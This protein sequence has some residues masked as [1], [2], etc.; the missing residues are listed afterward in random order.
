MQSGDT[1]FAVSSGVGRAAVCVIRI[2]GSR[3]QYV[4]DE[5]CDGMR[6]TPRLM[7]LCTLQDPHTGHF[8]DHALV[9]FFEGPKSFTGE[10]S[11]ELHVH[12]S[13]AVKKA[14]LKTLSSLEG[15]RPAERGEFTQR[16]FL[17]RKMDLAQVEGLAD[18]IDSETEQQRL[19]AVRQMDGI[20]GS[21]VSRWREL[22]LKALALIEGS[23]D[24]SDEEDVSDDCYVQLIALLEPLQQE[25]NILLNNRAGE[26]IRESFSIV[27]AGKP[28]TGKS[29]LLNLLSRRDVA[30]VSDIPGTTRDTLEVVCDLDGYP[31]IFTDTAGLRD[32]DDQIE[33][34]GVNRAKMKMASADLVLWLISP[35]TFSEEDL[36]IHDPVSVIVVATKSDLGEV[37]CKTDLAISVKESSNI[38]QLLDLIRS[39]IENESDHEGAVLTRERH[40]HAV[41]KAL[42]SLDRALMLINNDGPQELV[43]EDIRLTA[44]SLSML[45]GEVG[46]EDILGELFSNFC[47]GK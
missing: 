4:L 14:I 32:S 46:V 34:E 36:V 17:N 6:F 43:G 25:L 7:Q 24:F 22:L 13:I 18:L 28:N 5:L 33:V 15:C 29:S 9:V 10:D 20:L 30:I 42:E 26:R 8:L 19:Q 35:D 44:R 47:I 11:A 16:A 27:L 39:R 45:T 37:D 1:I 3:T 38:D 23:L 40:R 2:S 12:G 31:V 21:H 41:V